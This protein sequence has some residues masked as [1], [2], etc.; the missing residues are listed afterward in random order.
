MEQ[1][2]SNNSDDNDEELTTNQIKLKAQEI[3]KR[4]EK[5]HGRYTSSSRCNTPLPITSA[6]SIESIH[7]NSVI[8]DTSDKILLFRQFLENDRKLV[9]NSKIDEQKCNN[10]D[11]ANDE[12]LLDV[13]QQEKEKL[14]TAYYEDIIS[15]QLHEKNIQSLKSQIAELNEKLEN[16]RNNITEKDMLLQLKINKIEALNKSI[17]QNKKIHLEMV[18]ELKKRNIEIINDERLRCT[19]KINYISEEVEELRNNLEDVHRLCDKLKKK[20]IKIDKENTELRKNEINLKLEIEKLS[21]NYENEKKLILKHNQETSK[22]LIGDMEKELLSLQQEN[23]VLSNHVALLE[24]KSMHFQENDSLLMEIDKKE[25]EIQRLNL[26]NEKLNKQ[27]HDQIMD[28]QQTEKEFEI[29]RLKLENEK[30]N[31]QLQDQIMDTQQTEKEF[32]IQRLKLENEKLNKQLQEQIMDT[33]QTE[34]ESEIQRLKLENEKLNKQLQDQIMDTQQTEKESEIQRLNLENEKLNKQLQD[35][36]M[37]TQQTEKEFEIQRLNFENEKLNKQLQD[38]IIDAQQTESRWIQLKDA[39]LNDKER[40]TLLE[41]VID[42]LKM[43][44][45]ELNDANVKLTEQIEKSMEEVK[46]LKIDNGTHEER[47]SDLMAVI[48]NMRE[49]FEKAMKEASNEYEQN[50]INFIRQH[51]DDQVLITTCSNKLKDSVTSVNELTNQLNIILKENNLF[52]CERLEFNDCLT[53]RD[54][55]IFKLNN[56]IKEFHTL[57]TQ[58]TNEL[59]VVKNENNMLLN[60]LNGTNIAVEDNKLLSDRYQKQKQLLKVKIKALKESESNCSLLQQQVASLNKEIN[61]LN[62]R[63]AYVIQN[64]KQISTVV[65]NCDIELQKCYELLNKIVVK[66]NLQ[67]QNVHILRCILMGLA[68]LFSFDNFGVEIDVDVFEVVNSIC[69]NTFLD[70]NE[71]QICLKKMVFGS[72]HILEYIINLNDSQKRTSAQLIERTEVEQFVSEAVEKVKLSTQNE[73]QKQNNELLKLIEKLRNDNYILQSNMSSCTLENKEVLTDL[74]GL[75]INSLLSLENLDVKYIKNENDT[76]KQFLKNIRKDLDLVITDEEDDGELLN[77]LNTLEFHVHEIKNENKL[78]HNQVSEQQRL[79]SLK[80]VEQPIDL[81]TDKYSNLNSQNEFIQTIEN[82]KENDENKKK[83]S[84]ELCLK[85]LNDSEILTSTK[86]GD[87]KMLL[88]RYKNLKS[89]FKECRVK[90]IDL[91]KKIV[92]LTNDLEC[93]NSKYKQLNDQYSNENET[94]EADIINCQS[95]IENLMGEKLEAYRQLTALKE[96]HEI[97]QNDYDQLKS[98]LDDQNSLNDT[99]TTSLHINEQ[100]T[101]LK[102]RLKETQRLIDSAYS[103]VLCEWPVIENDS[104]WVVIQSKKLDKIVD[105][106]CC[107]SFYSSNLGESE[108][109]RLQTCVQTIHELVTSILTNINSIEVS[110]SN[111]PIDLMSDLKSCT[112][113]LLEFISVKNNKSTDELHKELA[114]DNFVKDNNTFIPEESSINKSLNSSEEATQSSLLKN[115]EKEQLLR[116]IAERDRLIEFLSVKISKLDKLNQNVDDLRLVQDKLDRA[117]TAVHERD[118]RCDE[119]TLEL[120]RLLEERD[121]LQLKL[122]NSIRQIQFLS[123]NKSQLGTSNLFDEK[124]DLKTMDDKL[125]ELH[126]LEYRRDAELFTNQEQRH[127]SQMQLHQ[128]RQNNSITLEENSLKTTEEAN[129]TLSWFKDILW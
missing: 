128:S 84:E 66:S 107:D 19:E 76:L 121:M 73:Y 50:K 67:N 88:V 59:E 24:S 3:A 104:D 55:E 43:N 94:H 31:K 37:D 85:K 101:V 28:T 105:A 114:Q 81:E 102:G 8:S 92:N 75:A 125:E 49:T 98:N 126:S 17:V 25:S 7:S 13:Q 22:H 80:T 95:E 119:L 38:Q 41:K 63:L 11:Q 69:N 83:V 48:E 116:S 79:I 64:N 42:E 120:T 45:N 70:D 30:L 33:Q 100:N 21:M 5:Y 18:E 103:R 115:E 78:L 72:I 15:T 57:S 6:E 99:N 86:N 123:D 90:I 61:V 91:E 36:I 39:Y 108:I 122:S 112:E 74:N 118:V 124:F 65:R 1:K 44:N 89:R 77:S 4:I 127:M 60:K 16:Y 34:K 68:S 23:D 97:L 71:L 54:T 14:N 87:S 93:V 10:G 20:N 51:E 113:T 2:S 129:T 40:M 32:E 109:K 46:L 12:N 35:Q 53:K 110:S 52:K 47:I 56:T 117:L 27:L 111:V 106:K 96:K 29:Q 58:L 62:Q 26:E 9:E 82:F